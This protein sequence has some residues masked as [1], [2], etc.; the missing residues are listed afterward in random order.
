MKKLL[1]I[2]F[3]INCAYG[4]EQGNS[5]QPTNATQ[6]TQT[7]SRFISFQDNQSPYTERSTLIRL[8]YA[9]RSKLIRA[10][11]FLRV[12]SQAVPKLKAHKDILFW[13]IDEVTDPENINAILFQHPELAQKW[14]EVRVKLRSTKQQLAFRPKNRDKEQVIFG[15]AHYLSSASSYVDALVSRSEERRVGKEC[16]S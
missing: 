12:I 3:S 6:D 10:N 11:D 14:L 5:V 8:P 9:E 7:I 4:M 13:Y 2:I 15:L 1:L 16:R